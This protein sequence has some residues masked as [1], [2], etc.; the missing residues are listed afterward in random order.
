MT[1]SE[2]RTNK[3][4]FISI[5]RANIKRD[6]IENL[7][8][9]LNKSDFFT[10]P[11]STRFHG[12]YEGG[13]CEHSL[14]VYHV[15][16][17][18]LSKFDFPELHEEITDETITIITLFHDICK[19]FY[20]KLGTRNMKID[21]KWETVQVYEVDDKLPLGHGE[22]SCMILQRFMKL[23]INELMAIRWHMGAFDFAS[24]GGDRGYDLAGDKTQ[25][26]NLLHIADLIA[27]QLYEKA[28]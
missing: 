17:E 28:I 10:A 15:F 26:V 27:S 9:W 1:E 24:K 23:S 3:E 19:A 22:K 4:N 2:I 20:Y 18:L 11:S 14:N 5:V 6:G 25:L 21:D 7:I 16:K 12:N 8:D 13:L